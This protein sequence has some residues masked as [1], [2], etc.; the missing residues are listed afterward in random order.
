[1][2]NSLSILLIIGVIAIVAGLLGSSFGQK[3]PSNPSDS[4]NPTQP[5]VS[6]SPNPSGVPTQVTL[7]GQYTCL[8]H[9]DTSGP[10]TL[11]CALGL[12]AT[13][14]PY[15][16]L[17]TNSIPQATVMK[18]QTGEQLT[19]TGTLVPIEQISSNTWQKY[20]IEGIVKVD[21]ME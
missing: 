20:A 16:A 14:G 11:E 1:M 4:K 6:A 19:V 13:T 10:V 8:P 18:L 12:Q 17:D 3:T 9:R 15:Y 21:S 5:A 7:T 2:K